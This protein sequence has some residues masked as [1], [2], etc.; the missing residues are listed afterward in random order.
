MTP[1]E[2]LQVQATYKAY[3]DQVVRDYRATLVSRFTQSIE[4]VLSFCKRYA[5]TEAGICEAVVARWIADHANDVSIWD[6][7]Y[8]NINGGSGHGSRAIRI[9][10][11]QEIA[12]RQ[13]ASSANQRQYT[14]LYL[15]SRR[16]MP[17]RYIPGAHGN[18]PAGHPNRVHNKVE[19]TGIQWTGNAYT[20][21]QGMIGALGPTRTGAGGYYAMLA[22]KGQ[23][24]HVMGA[25]FGTSMTGYTDVAFF[26][27]N[28]GDFW[29]AK[30][31]DFCRFL[32]DFIPWAYPN[33]TGYDIRTFGR[34]V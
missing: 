31:D 24:G 8:A 34:A 10:V 17:R 19:T 20:I 22:V 30:N 28:Y 3:Q 16:V 18:F 32:R 29:F 1:E 4:P 13:M 7:L 15:K 21:A 2:L 33:Y 6:T 25:Y 9:D 27:P 11:M 5:S 23:G 14:E 26:D 12:N